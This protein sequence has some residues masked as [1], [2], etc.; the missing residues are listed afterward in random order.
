MGGA[1][2]YG[3]NSLDQEFQLRYDLCHEENTYMMHSQT[4][5]GMTAREVILKVSH[6]L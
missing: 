4:A 3:W 1:F 5:Y 6:K 2:F